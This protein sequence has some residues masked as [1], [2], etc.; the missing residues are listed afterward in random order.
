MLNYIVDIITKFKNKTLNAQGIE[1]DLYKALQKGD[2][3]A[4]L[5][6]FQNREEEVDNAIKEYNPQTHKVM[7]RRN[8]YRKNDRPTSPRNCH[9]HASVTSTRW[10]CSSCS[11]L[12][13]VGRN[14]TATMRRTNCSSTSYET[15]ALTRRC[16]K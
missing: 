14:S 11:A 12:R 4:A 15:A 7:Q 6:M 13:S 8:K 2:V 10:S 3:S 16:A 1:S 9:A 5:S